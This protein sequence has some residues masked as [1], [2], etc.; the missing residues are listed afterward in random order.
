MGR[1]CRSMRRSWRSP[2][3][4]PS[5]R[6][7]GAARCC[8]TTLTSPLTCWSRTSG[9]STRWPTTPSSAT[10][11]RWRP[12]R[13]AASTSSC[14][15]IR[16][17]PWPS[18]S[19]PNSSATET[20]VGRYALRA[21]VG[22]DRIE[23]RAFAFLGLLLG[24]PDIYEAG[25]PLVR[26]QAKRAAHALAIGTP[27][28]DP[29]RAVAERIG[30]EDEILAGGAGRQD[31]LPFRRPLALHHPRDHRDHERRAQEPLRLV[32]EP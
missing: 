2:R 30:G 32:L 12:R 11:S 23:L 19:C 22:D 29:L 1:S 3:S 5:A 14:C 26:G 20:R 25:H 13:K 10:S 4:V 9:P 16:A 6:G 17:T 28:G 8:P 27:L 31:L 15:S 21:P 24:R 18:A 7:A